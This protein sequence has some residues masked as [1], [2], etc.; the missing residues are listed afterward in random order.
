MKASFI[1][2]AFSAARWGS[3]IRTYACQS[4][5]L[6]PYRLA[7]PHPLQYNIF[8]TKLQDPAGNFCGEPQSV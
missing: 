5:S 3:R 1:F 6:V 7:M 8:R 2:A 4:Q